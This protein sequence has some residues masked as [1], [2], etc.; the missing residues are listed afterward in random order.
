[1]RSDD[2]GE[3]WREI[4]GDLPTDFGFPVDVHAHDPEPSTLSPLRAMH[5]TIRP[6]ANFASTAASPAATSGN[7][8]LKAF[9]KT[10]AT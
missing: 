2:A 9:R 1:M 6:K 8:S 10:T 3:N 5:S 7:R 4:S